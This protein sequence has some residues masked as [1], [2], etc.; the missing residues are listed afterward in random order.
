M[1]T[2]RYLAFLSLVLIGVILGYLLA[3]VVTTMP[4]MAPAN[5]RA[6]ANAVTVTDITTGETLKLVYM[7]GVFSLNFPSLNEFPPGHTYAY[8]RW[9]FD[10]S[11]G[12][13]AFMVVAGP[14][15]DG[16]TYG[17]EISRK[18]WDT[19]KVMVPGGQSFDFPQVTSVGTPA[20]GYVSFEFKP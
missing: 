12:V 6:V 2:K 5:H 11:T 1:D 7:G 19:L 4:I 18:C 9:E 16:L 17:I 14:G 15:V 3:Y 13:E 20:I 10:S 8:S